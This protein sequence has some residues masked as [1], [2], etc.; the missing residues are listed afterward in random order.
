ML[1][2]SEFFVI[3]WTFQKSTMAYDI[4][5]SYR[6]RGAG[7]GVAGELQ[8]KLEN[9]GY[10][11]FLDVDE[12]AS[13]HFPSQI[14]QAIAECRDFIL[15]LAPGTLDRC[16]EEGDWVRC[17]I[18][19]AERLGKNIVG[20]ALSGFV[21][22][23]KET[24]P[25]SLQDLPLRQVFL[26]THE[27]RVASFAKIE[28][29]LVS[30]IVKKKKKRVIG[31]AMASVALLVLLGAIVFFIMKQ[32][33][34]LPDEGHASQP[35][36]NQTEAMLSYE[37]RVDRIRTMTRDLPTSDEVKMNFQQYVS[38]QDFFEDLMVSIAEC[39]TLIMLKNEYGDAITNTF[40][41]EATRHSLMILR[42]AFLD[43]FL[44]DITA[45]LQLDYDDYARDD[46]KMAKILALPADKQKLDS[47]ESVI[48][49][50]ST[51]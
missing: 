2:V 5:I 30:T 4:F 31:M 33:L 19:E 11:V 14:R 51:R 17:E 37:S 40:D 9:R 1:F 23:P 42:E 47:I 6:R 43:G 28:E 44:A 49:N 13:G 7:A 24:L 21:M 26:W 38:S 48:N 3:S 18:E 46:L 34:S 8:A 32:S 36:M 27:Y 16:V 35:G 10:K 29:N 45:M 50:L 25:P 12:I 39:D 20:V 41:V 15:V 22:P